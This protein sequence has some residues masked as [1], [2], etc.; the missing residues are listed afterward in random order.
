MAIT[1]IT[2]S[3]IKNMS[4]FELGFVDEIDFTSLTDTTV[5]KVN[6][7]YD[8][9]LL[10]VL[11]SY[12]WRFATKRVSIG[13]SISY[14]F[15]VLSTATDTISVGTGLTFVDGNTVTITS[16]GDIEGLS[17]SI[18]YYVV[19]SSDGT[20]KLSLTSG[21]S[22]VDITVGGSGSLVY[23]IGGATEAGNT[24]KF[25]YLYELPSDMLTFSTAFTDEY[26]NCAIRQFETNQEY[27]N[28]DD[29]T[30]YLMYVSNVA[31]TVFPQYFINYFKY[32]LAMDLC[33]NLTG[34]TDLLKIL[35]MQTEQA[36][37]QAK[38]TDARQNPTRTIKY[39]PFTNVRY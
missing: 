36:R 10:S 18:T 16:L 20:C 7:I 25:K 21:G 9:C 11:S 31:E 17:V 8:T 4:L 5:K 35:A 28:T 39:S 30:A 23:Y 15:T 3:A 6:R 38:N 14:P 34:D 33:F 24:W 1:G 27:L 37:I 29:T 19:S 13:S 2:A 26:Y 12:R 32:R 22:A